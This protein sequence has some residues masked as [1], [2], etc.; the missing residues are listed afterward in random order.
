MVYFAKGCNGKETSCNKSFKCAIGNPWGRLLTFYCGEW[1]SYD[2]MK[3][4]ALKT[5]ERLTGVNNLDQQRRNKMYQLEGRLDVEANDIIMLVKEIPSES[6]SGEERT[7]YLSTWLTIED[8]INMARVR[9]LK[10]KILDCG[11]RRTTNI[12][13]TAQDCLNKANGVQ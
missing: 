12:K 6:Y 3:I 13:L 11:R 4:E 8:Y 10:N 2:E 5:F 9:Q 1:Q 7:I